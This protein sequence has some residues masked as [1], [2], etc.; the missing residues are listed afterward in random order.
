VQELLND[1]DIENN[2]VGKRY[3]LKNRNV[4]AELATSVGQLVEAQR[5][6]GELPS[7]DALRQ[8][9][10]APSVAEAAK[11]LGEKGGK[12]AS[13]AGFGSLPALTVGIVA[14]A[15]L[16]PI[17]GGIALTGSAGLEGYANGL[18]GALAQEGVDVTNPSELAAAV[19]D[20]DLMEVVRR[21]ATTQGAI[22]AGLAAL[23]S[24]TGIRG[25]AKLP[26]A[27]SSGEQEAAN[28]AESQVAATAERQAET[29]AV[30]ENPTK[31]TK[32]EQL[33][34]NAAR[35]KEWEMKIAADL[36]KKMKYDF[37]QQVEIKTPNGPPIRIDFV[38][39]DP[40]TK[41][42]FLIDA[43]DVQKVVIKEKNQRLAY[44]ELAKM[45]GVI[46]RRAWPSLEGQ[47]EFPV[48]TVIPPT[49]V[50]IQ[51]P[52]GAYYVE[53]PAAANRLSVKKWKEQPGRFDDF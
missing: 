44:P 25:R 8:L 1:P 31:L 17:G 11:L 20:K 51:T 38:V 49:K 21:K 47:G 34:A 13:A 5:K 26:T 16:G 52:K 18:I 45:G 30:S 33:A 46:T 24:M 29:A 32:A 2:V 6:L 12:I 28:I 36:L 19:Q 42:I 22:N 23:T 3:L 48:G 4:A 39:R 14:S 41:R 43:K 37:A 10:E 7:S 50:Q 40:E 53:R 27:V 35:G 15:A 9:F